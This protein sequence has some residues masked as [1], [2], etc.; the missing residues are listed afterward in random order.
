MHVIFKRRLLA[1]TIL[2]GLFSS[3]APAFGETPKGLPKGHCDSISAGRQLM[4]SGKFQEALRYLDR[5]LGLP[6]DCPCI[7]IG[8]RRRPAVDDCSMPRYYRGIVHLR[9]AHYKQAADDFE[10]MFDHGEN[11]VEHQIRLAC[12]YLLGGKG[13]WAVE[14][15][16]G[17]DGRPSSQSWQK[18]AILGHFGYL[19]EGDFDKA[20]RILAAE[21]RLPHSTGFH[22]NV[23]R[24][25]HNEITSDVLPVYANDGRC[26]CGGKSCGD[27]ISKRQTVDAR[28][29][30]G[31]ERAFA[32][33]HDDARQHLEWVI[34]N[35]NFLDPMHFLAEAELRHRM[36]SR[37]FARRT[38][39]PAS[40]PE[41]ESTSVSGCN[42]AKKTDSGPPLGFA[43]AAENEIC[44]LRRR[45]PS[46]RPGMNPNAKYIVRDDKTGRTYSYGADDYNQALK[47]MYELNRDI[48]R[49]ATMRTVNP[50]FATDGSLPS[51]N[52]PSERPTTNSSL[53]ENASPFARQAANEIGAL[54]RRKPSDRPTALSER[55]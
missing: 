9:L 23:V 29:C 47:K 17:R 2:T 37:R 24:Y 53:L 41:T 31:L 49:K 55:R 16:E 5:A 32:G 7:M 12:L 19:Q 45:K 11:N 38:P 39:V 26:D 8:R 51:E 13:N 18:M 1:V 43:E 50:D 42:V 40:A 27:R 48:D 54:Q 15:F 28:L 20:Q 36:V 10:S 34:N 46:E 35:Q 33:R 6:C 30:I 14:E 3:G 52:Q 21:L 22:R 44:S 25:L 4:E